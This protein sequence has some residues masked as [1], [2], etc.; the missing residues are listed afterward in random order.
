MSRSLSQRA[1]LQVGAD[2]AKAIMETAVLGDSIDADTMGWWPSACALTGQRMRN[3]YNGGVGGDTTTMALARI[4]NVIYQ[5]P[6]VCIIGGG[7]TNDIAQGFA[8]ATTQTNLTSMVTQ[9]RAAGIK[10]LF[11]NCPPRGAGVAPY[12]TDALA[13]AAVNAH[14]TWLAGYAA[15]QGLEVFDIY[16][17]LVNPAT[18]LYTAGYSDDGIHPNAVG[19]LV[20]ARAFRD[21][22]PKVFKNAAPFDLTKKN[23][24]TRVTNPLNIGATSGV[25]NGWSNGSGFTTKDISS[26]APAGNWQHFARTDAPWAVATQ[27]PVIPGGTPLILGY[28]MSVAAGTAIVSYRFKDNANTAVGGWVS[29]S[30]RVAATKSEEFIHIIRAISPANASSMEI[31]IENQRDGLGPAV[32]FYI[33]QF[34]LVA[35]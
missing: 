26:A 1:T 3:L 6:D 12:N 25:A 27:Q 23:M 22:L 13:I 29:N 30:I 21:N 9:L 5:T 24:G 20:V 31:W 34:T 35:K 16:T 32:D 28:R 11:R 17:P 2:A 14:T 18:S 33:A 10:P 4:A 8:A 7:V 15:S 19:S